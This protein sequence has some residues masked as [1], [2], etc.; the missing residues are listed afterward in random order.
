MKYRTPLFF[1]IS[2]SLALM[3]LVLFQV[4]WINNDFK[5]KEDVFKTKVEEALI[6][7]V[8]KLEKLDPRGNY[9]KKTTRTQ[10]IAYG[11]QNMGKSKGIGI[12]VKQ[13]FSV[14]SNGKQISRFSQKD[15]TNDSILGLN[16]STLNFLYH[17]NKKQNLLSSS[18]ND[19]PST[20]SGNSFFDQTIS[21]NYYNGLIKK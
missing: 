7:T 17:F 21:E 16:P 13:E 14:D 12:S 9:V 18:N 15:L 11:T 4:Y 1:S 19:L 10:G 2:F 20:R 8:V 5:I 6:N 3:V